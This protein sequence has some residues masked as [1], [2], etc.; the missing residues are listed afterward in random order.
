MNHIKPESIQIS[1]SSSEL[2]LI[3]KWSFIKGFIII[4]AVTL[5]LIV[6]SFLGL[7]QYYPLAWIIL[8]SLV[9]LY[10]TLHFFNRTYVRVTRTVI[11][12]T[13]QPLRL[14]PLRTIR[15]KNISQLYVKETIFKSENGM[16]ASYSVQYKNMNGEQKTLIKGLT[17]VNAAVFTEKS[18]ERWLGIEDDFHFETNDT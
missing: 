7:V 17:S 5:F 15:V 3:H 10:G 9:S 4:V 14:I 12:I 6:A 18:I 8:A 11:S 16:S 2:L 13:H 1:E